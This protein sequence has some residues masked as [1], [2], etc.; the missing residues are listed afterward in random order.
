MSDTNHEEGAASLPT[1]APDTPF[2]AVDVEVMERNLQ[3][4]ADDARQRGIALRPHAKT[5]KVP[6]IGRRQLAL[7]A[8]GLTLATVGEAEVFADAGFT[9]LFI[10]YPVWPSDGR[11][12]RLRAL[13]ERVS[14]RVGVDSVES[15]EALGRALAGSGAQVMVEI[16]SGHHRSGVAPDQAG[17]VAAAADSAGLPVAGVFTFPGHGYSPTGLQQAARDEADAISI[18]AFMLERAGLDAPIR[19]GGSTPTR[20]A[21]D[22]DVINE[23]RP[24]V[25]V[26]NDAQQVEL[27]TCSWEDVALTAYATVVSR[28]GQDVIADAGSKVLGADQPS[29]A[30]GGGRLPDFPDA[31]VT[32]LS[33]HHATIRFP[34]GVATPELGSTLRIAPNHVCAAVNL[35]NELIVVQ[36]GAVVDSWPVAARGANS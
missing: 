33:E 3:R 32:A 5:H 26:F 21:T 22:T 6:E 25:Y 17:T 1:N 8:V 24:G 31:R 4:A 34:D 9:D 16:D 35:A 10:A 18:A 28:R 23:L 36:N 29:W 12:A 30:T 14:L 20:A 15:A 13:A 11:T 27:G 7:G 19:S 2:L